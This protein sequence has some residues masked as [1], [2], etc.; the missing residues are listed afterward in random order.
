MRILRTWFR[1]RMDG[2][3]PVNALER[4]SGILFSP[5]LERGLPVAGRRVEKTARVSAELLF[6]LETVACV[7]TIS[8]R[9]ENSS[10]AGFDRLSR[11][12]V[13]DDYAIDDRLQRARWHRVCGDVEGVVVGPKP[14]LSGLRIRPATHENCGSERQQCE[15]PKH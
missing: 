4:H 6:L 9:R 15:T 10:F 3:R 12:L 14:K 2:L 13:L 8:A 1:S 7:G 11:L 5:E